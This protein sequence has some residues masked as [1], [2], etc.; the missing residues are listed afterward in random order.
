VS[1]RGFAWLGV[2]ACVRGTKPGSRIGRPTDSADAVGDTSG[3]ESPN[4][5]LIGWCRVVSAACVVDARSIAA[6]SFVRSVVNACRVSSRVS[7]T[8]TPP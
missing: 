4:S 6:A 1:A 8:N 2:G 5:V 7:I 3:L